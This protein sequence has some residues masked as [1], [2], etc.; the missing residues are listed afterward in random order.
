MTMRV[1]HSVLSLA[2]GYRLFWKLVGG[3][4]LMRILVEEYV[5]LKPGARVLD[6][7]CG[8]GVA[9]PYFPN[10]EYVGFDISAEYIESARRRFPASTFVSERISAYTLSPHSFDLVLALGVVHHLE[11]AEAFQL[12]RI[13]HQALKPGCKLVTSDPVFTDSQSTLA[14]YFVSLDRGEFVRTESGYK[15]IAS[16][17]FSALHTTVRNDLL[18]IPYSH[19]IMECSR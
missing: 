12:F 7:G 11:D 19:I 4:R 5:Q 10:T 3:P 15:G 13:A 1:T 8:P 18:R 14:R 16:E 6:I 17:I 9:V 2:R